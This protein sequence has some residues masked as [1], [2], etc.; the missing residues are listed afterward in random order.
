MSNYDNMSNNFNQSF[1]SMSMGQDNPNHPRY[2][3]PQK[4]PLTFGAMPPIER[5]ESAMSN[6]SFASQAIG[7][8]SLNTLLGQSN[9]HITPARETFAPGGGYGG[10]RG[11]SGEYGQGQGQNTAMG[12]GP[13]QGRQSTSG[14]GGNGGFAASSGFSNGQDGRGG[15]GAGPQGN[16]TFG[17]TA[18][19]YPQ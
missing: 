4:R 13:Q 15:Y 17:Q 3:P 2:V 12:G 16:Y 6:D 9:S 5:P 10:Q 8:V 18:N 19:P 14:Y 11:Y 7:G 1:A